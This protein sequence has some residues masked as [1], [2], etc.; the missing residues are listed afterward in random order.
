MN[1]GH[2]IN[3]DETAVR[4]VGG[5]NMTWAKRVLMACGSIAL[6]TPRTDRMRLASPECGQPAARVAVDTS[7]NLSLTGQSEVSRGSFR[8]QSSISGGE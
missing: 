3:P 8:S 5:R 4:I 7:P 6:G 2:L 1:H